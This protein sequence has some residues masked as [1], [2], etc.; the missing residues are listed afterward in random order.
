MLA[1]AGR[2]GTDLPPSLRASL[3]HVKNAFHQE[4]VVRGLRTRC[5]I[6]YSHLDNV[7]ERAL[8]FDPIYIRP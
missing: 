8:T 6:V 1:E 4:A 7:S 5:M 2:P 3:T